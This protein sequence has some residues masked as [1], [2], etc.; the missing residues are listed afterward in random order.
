M[1]PAG[2]AASTHLKE[3]FPNI[4][5][6]TGTTR[7][8]SLQPG[9][10]VSGVV[11]NNL[12]QPLLENTDVDIVLPSTS[13]FFPPSG[14][15]ANS[16]DGT[17]SIG[18]VPTG[19][20]TFEFEPPGNSGFPKQRLSR[21]IVGPTAQT[22]DFT[23]AIGV[24]LSGT[25]V[26]DNGTTPEPNVE[27]KP[28]PTNGTLA[29]DNDD[30]DGSGVYE[31][32]LFPGTYT[33]N[34]TPDP[35]NLQVPEVQTITV[36][37]NA[38]LNVTLTRGAILTGTVTNGGPAEPNIKV[39]IAGVTGASDVTDGSGVYS[40]LAPVGTHTLTL[41][42][43]AGSLQDMALQPVTGVVVTTPG[44][45]TENIALSLAATGSTV[46]QGTVFEPD[47]T[48]PLA[49]A[50]VIARDNTTGNVLGKAISDGSGNY[51]LVIP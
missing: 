19:T 14:V 42:A 48:T 33:V 34:I 37:A 9:V 44:P 16:A 13:N 3:K 11:R 25:I 45:V 6:S 49:G 4:V 51:V 7:N 1:T 20:I 27:V 43:E 36:I 39:E 46:V 29:P 18:P 8:F 41:T 17:Y 24:I 2:A 47:G 22:E 10:T 50:E 31:I 38:T 28:I 32:S 30:T 5:V 26:Q 40:F 21:S 12:G 15:T 35:T 23:L